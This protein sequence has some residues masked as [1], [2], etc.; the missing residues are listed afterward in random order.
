MIAKIVAE[1]LNNKFTVSNHV[2]AWKYYK[3]RQQGNKPDGCKTDFCQFDEA[4][5]DY[6]YTE[7]WIDFLVEK[8]SD[9]EE[10]NKVITLKIK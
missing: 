9:N 2:Q 4:H 5:N 7:K 6:I 1:K 8:L 10:Y 3:V